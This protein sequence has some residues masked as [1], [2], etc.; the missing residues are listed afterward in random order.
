MSNGFFLD[1]ESGKGIWTPHYTQDGH[2]YYYNM[3]RNESRWDYEFG[4]A[5]TVNNQMSSNQSSNQSSLP[6]QMDNT[7]TFPEASIISNESDLYK[8]AMEE[9]QKKIDE[10]KKNKENQKNNERQL[11][12][13][14]KMYLQQIHSTSLPEKDEAA[15]N[16]YIVK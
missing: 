2:L 11:T 10:L 6:I 5:P 15:G 7:N 4:I 1:T 8:I 13:E 14:E 12:E 16:K 9:R 3:M